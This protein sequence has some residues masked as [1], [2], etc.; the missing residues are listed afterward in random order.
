MA[1]RPAGRQLCKQLHKSVRQVR[2]HPRSV[3]DS[4]GRAYWA[5]VARFAGS[6]RGA[7]GRRLLE[8]GA[9]LRSGVNKPT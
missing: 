1:E 5:D 6:E 3:A 7:I 4:T 8:R 9:N 2:R